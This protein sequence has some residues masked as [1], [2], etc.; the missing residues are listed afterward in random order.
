[1]WVAEK[2]KKFAVAI[3]NWNGC[4]TRY[5]LS[6]EIGDTV[7]IL[8]ECM[9]WYR[10]FCTKNRSIK[11]IFPCSYVYVK[12]CKIENEGLFETAVPLEDPAVRE[13][14]LV[15]R[16]W[17]LIWKNAYVD[18]ETYKFTILR[19][20]MWELLDWR[21]QLLMGTLTQDQTKELKLRITSKID[22]GNRKLGLDLVPRCE[23]EQVDPATMSIVELYHVHIQSSESTQGISARG[24]IRRREVDKVLTHH[25]YLCMRDFGHYIGEDTEVYFSLYD[26]KKMKFISERFLVKISKEGFSNYIEK[27]NSN[28]TIFID[29]GNSDLTKDTFIVAHVMRVGKMLYSDSSK[30][31]STSTLSHSSGS[32]FKRPNGVAVLNIGD[33]VTSSN[34][35]K[36]FTFKV[37][38]CE[39]KD[40]YQL[41]EFIIKKQTNKFNVLPGQPNYG[42]DVS[43]R[44]LHGELNQVR[45]EN[46]LLF[47]SISL[48]RKLGFPDVI[49]PGDVRN[50][51]YLTLERGEFEKGGKSTGKNIEVTVLVLDSEGQ[52]IPNTLWGASGVDGSSEYQSMI[53]YHH[54]S[55]A[56][57]ETIR[58]TVP[59]E[60]Y[61][62]A[63]VRLEYKH[64]STRDKTDNKKL[65][66][67]SFARLMEPSGA[68][69]QDGSHELFVFRC[70]EKSKLDP[71]LYLGLA[72]GPNDP[73]GKCDGTVFSV[74]HKE[75]VYIRTLL[76]STKL[77]QNVD[78]LYLL[79]WKQH[80]ERI[81]E[82][83]KRALKLDGEELVKFLQDVLDALFS[84]FSTEDGNSTSHSGLVFHVLVSIFSLL[85]DSKFE[86]FKPVMDA[87]IKGHFAAALVYKGLLSSVQ[88]CA[89]WVSST[90]KQEPIQKCFRSLEYIFKFII[91][92]RLL[93][94]QST[95][96]LYEDNFRRDLLLVFSALNKMLTVTYDVIL[97]TQ[98]ALLYG[99]SAVYDQ[100]VL[101][102][103][104][105]EVT[106]LACS[107][108]ESLSV[109]DIPLQLVQA[110]LVAIK[111]MISGKL[112]K[113]DESR[114]IL[115]AT[116]C[117]HLRIHLAHR[118]ELRLCAEI[119]GEIL[120]FLYQQ[121]RQQINE[122]GKVNNCFHHDV[123]IIC[124][125]TLDMLIQT[126][127]IIIDRSSP[128][129]GCLVACLIALLQLLDEFH[130]KRLWEELADRKPLKDFLLRIFLVFRDLIRQ[131][132][133]PSDWLIMRMM[134]NSVI[135]ATLKELSQPLV[136]CFLESRYHFDNQVWSNYFNLAVEFLTQPSLQLEKF[137]DV[138][139]EKI[140]E[141]YG[142]MRVLMGFQILSVWSKL[143]EHKINFIP[144]MVGPFLEVTLVPESKL[145]KATL[146]IFF[147]MME[148]EQRA[149]GNFKQVESELIDKLDILIS[150]N[151][152]D[153]EYRQLFNTMEHLSAVLLDRVQSEDP[154]WKETGSAFISSVTRLL[155]RLLDYRSVIQGNE[156]RDKRMSCTVNLLNF[157]KNEI[158]RKEMYLRYIYKLHDLHCPADNFTEAGFTL[159]LYADSLSWESKTPL[160]NDP[161][162]PNTFEWRRK[163]QLYHQIINYFDKG[164]CWEN[165]IP[166]CKEL[167]DLYE[168][169]LFDY[170]K[171][172]SILQTQ[173][174]FCDNILHQLRPEPEY[175]RVGFYGLSF[176]LFV[177]NKVFVYRGL[178]YERIEAFTQRLQ[179]EFPCAQV[180]TKNSPP[181]HTILESEGQW[182]QITNVKPLP[183]S[184]PPSCRVPLAPVPD[185]VARFYQ[186]NDVRTFQL[187]RPMHKGTVDKENEFKTLWLERTILSIASPLPGILRWFEVV[188][189]SMEEVPPVR[190]ACETMQNVNKDLRNLI[191]QYMADPRRNINPLSMRLQGI[192]DA[193][194]MGG[195]A[196]YQQAFF[197]QE[198]SRAN[199]QWIPH[200]H[201]LNT[202][203]QEQVEIVENGLIIHG[204][205]APAGVQPLHK[206][207]VERISELKQSIRKC[208]A[209]SIIN[210]PLPPLPTEKKGNSYDEYTNTVGYG[211]LTDLND[212]DIY[213]KP[214]ELQEDLNDLSNQDGNSP[215]AIPQRENRP[216]SAGFSTSPSS[217]EI[218]PKRH[219]RSLSKPLSPKLLQ[220]HSVDSGTGSSSNLRN[221]W[222]DAN[223]DEAPPLPPRGHTPDKHATS[224]PPVLPKRPVTRR[225]SESLAE[226]DTDSFIF[227]DSGYSDNISSTNTFNNL[228]ISSQYEEFILTPH[229]G[230]SSTNVGVNVP[231]STPPVPPPLPP[232]STV[233][234]SEDHQGNFQSSSTLNRIA[235]SENYSVPKL[236]NSDSTNVKDP[237]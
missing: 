130:Y 207:L 56:W 91:H 61:Q 156:N 4:D 76:C 171:L 81:Q 75:M 221:S 188:H 90:E 109:R 73:V 196:K 88:H 110:K 162:S 230:N 159:K 228:S 139:R 153:D 118:D 120:S 107:L 47:K 27:L 150:E 147:D 218:K 103:P 79:Q 143:G 84:M 131:D 60:K 114:S 237:A 173:A 22:W 111:N 146:H 3:Y 80:P 67:F 65:F 233:A 206:R 168:H 191:S 105:L 189:S 127:L 104:I 101:V 224:G 19:K 55:P 96:G 45:E 226:S 176:P 149:H 23:V 13:V 85:Y 137:S 154:S 53:I 198:F 43:L 204:K 212:D 15:L 201:Q 108:L 187:D 231:P 183:E 112:F 213:S 74:S 170:Q 102:L 128:V 34:E 119:L 152:G 169:R 72:S 87:Y 33:M 44:L 57:F 208:P 179:T 165:G 234:F 140:I 66:G 41:H 86:H 211:H 5:G 63:H 126:V 54:N 94:S 92:S 48:S 39:E 117:K 132:V 158:N 1:M 28:C 163:E 35:E 209:D 142:D 177:R 24:T 30:K 141:K 113:E 26:A 59:I 215:P 7:Q 49:M 115:L 172:S 214:M 229:T 184:G 17:N 32:G 193:N 122:G 46:P 164:K 134:T 222:S 62:N 129:L 69:L 124:L 82:A 174:K 68:T 167:A 181:S 10:G 144:S 236:Q 175:F 235:S 71:S 70:Y 197:S 89:D 78:L 42:I 195:I 202:L 232:K 12:P 136:F 216:R 217:I 106:S 138:K 52:R 20:V 185:K 83:L 180:L 25:L 166:L 178:E 151:K 64:C 16:E 50:D 8:E 199:P 116:C 190:F 203:I 135:L 58:L 98:I 38:T 121:K 200:V 155:E 133:F 51:L 6:L 21:R 145:R 194:V 210:T 205:F 14:A 227:R 77:T 29:L 36:E 220:R 192:I 186:V 148:C 31:S 182:I 95:G 100:L 11:G 9:G 93:F 18:R 223:M 40:F 219:Q 157:Y 123:E 125:S 225:G 2:H 97:P 37:H 160:T 161:Q 99:I